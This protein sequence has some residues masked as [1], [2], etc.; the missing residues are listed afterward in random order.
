MLAFPDTRYTRATE[1]SPAGRAR[2]P[3]GRGRV[4]QDQSPRHEFGFESETFD[5]PV[6]TPPRHFYMICSTPRC[7]STWLGTLLWRTGLAGAPDEYFN[8]YSIM[9]HYARRWPVRTLPDYTREILRCRSGPNGV[10]GVKCHFDQFD[11]IRRLPLVI[12]Q[13]RSPR[14]IYMDRSDE[15]AQAVSAAF[16]AQSRQLRASDAPRANP[17]YHAPH[18]DKRM[19]ITRQFSAQWERFFTSAGV[20]PHRVRYEDL[21]AAPE[22]TIEGI[23]RFLGVAG[24]AASH[25]PALPELQ[26]QSDPRKTEWIE[27][28][29]RERGLV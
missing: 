12:E 19:A 8:Y 20:Q 28:Y 7:G 17:V 26:K 2:K 23:L 4:T 18:I 5:F 10:F 27:R 14:Y 11:F 29:K 6:A 9:L 22:P 24:Q 15:V 16:A 21:V 25:I 13:I 3:E 1:R